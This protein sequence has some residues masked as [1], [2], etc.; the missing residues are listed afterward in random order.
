MFSPRYIFVLFI[1]Y[2]CSVSLSKTIIKSRPFFSYQQHFL[3][4][5]LI[6]FDISTR[7]TRISPCFFIYFFLQSVITHVFFK[8]IVYVWI[9]LVNYFFVDKLLNHYKHPFEDI[10]MFYLFLYI[11][12]FTVI[13]RTSPNTRVHVHVRT[14]TLDK[15][16]REEISIWII[17]KYW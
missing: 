17:H 4:L 5:Y 9:N 12:I 11:T 1:Q 14:I 10:V 7:I 6:S 3:F 15:K 13:V 2:K 16:T 8:L